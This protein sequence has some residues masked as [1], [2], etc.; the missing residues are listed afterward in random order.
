MIDGTL[1]DELICAKEQQVAHYNALCRQYA[2]L[3]RA[4]PNHPSR[5]VVDRYLYCAYAR[6]AERA[7]LRYLTDI[8]RGGVHI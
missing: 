7:A 3:R 8:K 6:E 1:I 2:A 4:S 5:E